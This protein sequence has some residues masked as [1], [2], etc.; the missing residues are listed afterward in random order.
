MNIDLEYVNLIKEIMEKG[1]TI[2][3][4][5]SKVKRLFAKT[6]TIDSTPL[7]SIR[8]TSWK[9]ALYEME[10]FLS[11]SNKIKDL[12]PSVRHWWE[13]WVVD[14]EVFGNYSKQF[15]SYGG[16]TT[17]KDSNGYSNATAMLV[18][19]I[20]DF[21]KGVKEH[22]YSRR[23]LI[24][25]WNPADVKSNLSK[26]TNCHNTVTQAFVEETGHLSLV[27]YQRSCD[28]ICGLPHN[29]IQ[30]A[31]FHSWLAAKTDKLIGSLVWIGGDVHIYEQHF[32]LAKKIIDRVG[33]CKPTPVLVYTH[34]D[35]EFK[36]KNFSLRGDYSP[37]L[38]DTAVM[39]V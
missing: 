31:A 21:V 39:V 33:E 15:R 22:P 3:T 26:I 7:V 36:A 5:N 9:S 27:T 11:G 4:R 6:I 10:W 13:P 14:G 2:T 30:M 32:N 23:N 24:T 18:D 17:T 37:V 34:N 8:K 35:E 38:T 16:F 20:D 19:Q 28:V 1:C 12:K 29:L 25:T